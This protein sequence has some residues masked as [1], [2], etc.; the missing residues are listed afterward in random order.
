MPSDYSDPGQFP[1][2]DVILKRFEQPL[3]FLAAD[4]YARK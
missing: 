1:M 2:H 4:Q 3:H